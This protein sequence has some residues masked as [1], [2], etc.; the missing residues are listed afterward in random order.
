MALQEEIKQCITELKNHYETNL[1]NKFVKNIILKLDIGVEVR[2]QMGILLDYKSLYFDSKGTLFDLYTS[3]NAIVTFIK[4]IKTKV[5][6]NISNFAGGTFLNP[7]SDKDPN[8]KVLFQMA[9]K[10]YPMNIKIFAK[11]T[12]KLLNMIIE[13]DNANFTNNPAYLQIKN[14]DDINKYLN[15]YINEKDDK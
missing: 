9:V 8:N 13:Y 7:S 6:Q 5:L 10:N 11:Y 3:I 2:H 4:E 12:Y 14:F 1:N 15:E